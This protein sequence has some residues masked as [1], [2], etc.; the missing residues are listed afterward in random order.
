MEHEIWKPINGYDNDYEVSNYGNI[1]SLRYANNG[2]NKKGSGVKNLKPILNSLGYYV[3]NLYNNGK[4]KQYFVHRLVAETF[5][6]NTNNYP[7]ID[8]KNTITTDNRVENLRW[9]T[10]KDNVNNPI[11]SKRR[12]SKVRELLKGKTGV[13]SLT[14]KPVVQYTLDG[15]FVKR[16][17][18]MM[19][20]CRYYKIDSGSLTRACQG[21]YKKVKGFAWRYVGDNPPIKRPKIIHQFSLDG[22]LINS[23]VSMTE[24]EKVTGIKRSYICGCIHER[25]KTSGGYIWKRILNQ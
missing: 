7:V 13:E 1:R 15:V 4:V 6:P 16:W 14:H 9:C 21:E 8:H 20:A 17:G 25:C 5:I 24:A 11:S 2:T 3:V 19:D 12:I 22:K 23:F 18:C 10:V